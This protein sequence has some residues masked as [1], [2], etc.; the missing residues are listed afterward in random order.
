MFIF[1]ANLLKMKAPRFTLVAI[2][3]AFLAGVLSAETVNWTSSNID[4]TNDGISFSAAS[5]GT[6]DSDSGGLFAF[7]T[8]H[9]TTGPVTDFSGAAGSVNLSAGEFFGQEYGF[10]HDFT[11]GT[12]TFGFSWQISDYELELIGG[13]TWDTSGLEASYHDGT[14]LQEGQQGI[15]FD[16]IGEGTSTITLDNIHVASAF[17]GELAIDGEWRGLI[18]TQKFNADL[19]SPAHGANG[20]AFFDVG[21]FDSLAP[22]PEPSSVIL[23]ALGGLAMIARRRRGSEK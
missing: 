15:H 16:I 20:R 18:V 4:A 8:V 12:G 14:S 13:A 1:N 6:L 17:T 21:D 5:S 19:G 2:S 7:S 9:G 11:G 10:D 22:V 23:G 3:S